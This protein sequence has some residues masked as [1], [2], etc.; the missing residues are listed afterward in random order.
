MNMNNQQQ[1]FESFK[2]FCTHRRYYNRFH[3]FELLFKENSF[4]NVLQA[5]FLDNVATILLN[6][7]FYT[8]LKMKD[9]LTIR[10]VTYFTLILLKHEE[11]WPRYKIDFIKNIRK[12]KPENMA[13]R[14]CLPAI[15]RVSKVDWFAKYRIET[16]IFKTD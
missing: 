5:S 7:L 14:E 15:Y 13:R 11:V 12:T 16:S 6:Y 1:H 9:I 10:K 8:L 4:E 3:L 2:T